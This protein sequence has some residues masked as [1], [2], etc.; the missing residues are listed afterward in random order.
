MSDESQIF[1]AALQPALAALRIEVG[2]AQQEQMFAHYSKVVEANR[3]FNL[4]RITSPADA[5]VKH[6]AD[7]LAL[8]VMPE[9]CTD[10]RLEV[11]DVGTGAGFPAVPLAIVCETWT[12]VAI[13]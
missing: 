11:L 8:L 7:S 6:Y 12:I 4:T 2:P 1:H 3:E 10:R 13:D 5:A 9:F